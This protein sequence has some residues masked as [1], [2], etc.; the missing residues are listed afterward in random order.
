MG[1]TSLTL[2]FARNI[3]SD[4]ARNVLVFSNESSKSVI[5]H[6]LLC[7]EAEVDSGKALA[8][9]LSEEDLQKVTTAANK[10]GEL[11]F[12]SDC[13]YPQSVEYIRD[14][15][16][17]FAANRSIGLIVVDNIQL[18]DDLSP[19]PTRA[20]AV[21]HSAVVLKQLAQ[22]VHAPVLVVAHLPREVEERVNKRPLLSDL[23]NAGSLKDNADVVL[24]LY[25]HDF[26]V[27][28]S[29]DVGVA[30]ISI[31]KP[32]LGK[33]RVA[34]LAWIPEQHRFATIG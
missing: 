10:L 26:Y 24:F 1:K 29:P 9:T 23:W 31:E 19:T 11:P 32:S 33:R 18:L 14:K 16:L 21:S 28:D 27:G 13:S 5:S 3:A 20:A 7:A 12:W 34:R 2:G 4:Q 8:G 25:R 30:E 22:S 6:R 17:E 15:S